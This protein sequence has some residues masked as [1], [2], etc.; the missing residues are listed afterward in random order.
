MKLIKK[1]LTHIL[2]K[3]DLEGI[4]YIK[5]NFWKISLIKTLFYNLRYLPFRKA[6]KMPILIGTMTKVR[7]FGTINLPDYCYTGIFTLGVNV[8]DGCEEK[9]DYAIIYNDGV[10]NITGKTW[11]NWGCKLFVKKGAMINFGNR[12]KFGCKSRII[13][14]KSITIGDDVRFSWEEQLFDTDFHFLYNIDKDEYYPRTK[15]VKIG[16]RVFVGNRCSISKG[17][18]IPDGSV[19]S[20]CSKV[21]G[22]FS[23]EGENLLILGNPAKVVKK[24]VEMVNS[25]NPESELRISKLL[26][27]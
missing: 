15:P 17:T 23:K 2:D 27:E 11:L 7:K 22:D 20:S 14:Y 3:D 10:I 5:D 1:L 25:W 6:C 21:G 4:I 16:N 9:S 24:N 19:I 8:I 18:K 12:V 26:N 13:C